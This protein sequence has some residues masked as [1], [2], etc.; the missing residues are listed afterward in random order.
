[1]SDYYFQHEPAKP[2]HRAGYPDYA[3]TRSGASWVWVAIVLVAFA[4]LLGLGVSG[5]GDQPTP[6]AAATGE[7]LPPD[8]V[9][10][11]AVPAV[12]AD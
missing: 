9:V 2:G 5:A 3:Q 1:M 4:A 6:P 8:P 7:A 10:P 11:D 12:P